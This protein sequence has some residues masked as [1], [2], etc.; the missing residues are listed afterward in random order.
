MDIGIG[1]MNQELIKLKN[2]RNKVIDIE[3]QLGMIESD[4]LEAEKDLI[5]F[6]SMYWILKEN[7]DTLKIDGVVVIADEYKKI[8]K[9]F[10]AVKKKLKL[11]N[12]LHSTLLGKFDKYRDLREIAI[13]E[14]ETYKKFFESTS[15]IIQFDPSRRKK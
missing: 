4:L 6:D 9:E 8:I 7:L 14:Y 5:F 11:C 3:I 10:T 15:S 13:I 12:D 1:L 2:L